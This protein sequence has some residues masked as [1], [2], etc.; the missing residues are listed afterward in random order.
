MRHSPAGGRKADWTIGSAAAVLT[1]PA[2]SGTRFN[3]NTL[4]FGSRS[5]DLRRFGDYYALQGCDMA[6]AINSEI[7][8][9]LSALLETRV[10]RTFEFVNTCPV[11]GSP[12]SMQQF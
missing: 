5:E 11:G 6:R 3:H 10:Q 4:D 2:C 12:H 1:P 8:K 9:E 7:A